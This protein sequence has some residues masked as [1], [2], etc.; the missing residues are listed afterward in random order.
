MANNKKEQGQD[1]EEG[2]VRCKTVNA[3]HQVDQQ[4][5]QRTQ[6]IGEERVTRTEG[7]NDVEKTSDL[8][9]L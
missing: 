4:I 6:L 1:G 7:I 5:H 2:Q 8:P 9:P 3:G